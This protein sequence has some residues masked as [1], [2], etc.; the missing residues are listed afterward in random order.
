MESMSCGCFLAVAPRAAGA[1]SGINGGG[2]VS[3]VVA[4][5][6]VAAVVV[7]DGLR[8]KGDSGGGGRATASVPA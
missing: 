3:V 1:V 5:V 4:V 8:G 7:N 6:V 2:A